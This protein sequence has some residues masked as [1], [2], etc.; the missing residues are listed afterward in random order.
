MVREAPGQ[1]VCPGV[2][3]A[4]GLRLPR[5]GGL[6]NCPRRNFLPHIFKKHLTKRLAYAILISEVSGS[7]PQLNPELL[8]VSNQAETRAGQRGSLL[9][10]KISK[11][12]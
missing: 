2:Q 11:A 3:L 6:V 8:H 7:K 5:W 12:A 10:R 4:G 1:E 9:L